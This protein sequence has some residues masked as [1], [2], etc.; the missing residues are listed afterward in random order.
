MD[1]VKRWQ[2]RITNKWVG[3]AGAVG[4]GLLPCPDCG[5]PLIVH[6]LP[7][8]GVVAVYRYMRRRSRTLDLLLADDLLQREAAP[9][10]GTTSITEP[11]T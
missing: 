11:G 1:I 8:A 10:A 2:T 3:L 4:I 9:P 7:F 5:V 6:V